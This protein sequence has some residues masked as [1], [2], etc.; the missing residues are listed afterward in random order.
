MKERIKELETGDISI[1][2]CV[3]FYDLLPEEKSARRSTYVHGDAQTVSERA[4]TSIRS[5]PSHAAEE[6][7]R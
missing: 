3:K 4:R 6:A 1:R 5:K 2:S 7:L